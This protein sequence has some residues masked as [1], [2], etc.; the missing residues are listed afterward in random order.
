MN[1][2]E[3]QLEVFWLGIQSKVEFADCY[4]GGRK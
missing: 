3:R 1:E 2:F 4:E